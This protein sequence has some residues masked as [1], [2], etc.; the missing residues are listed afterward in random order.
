[1]PSITVEG[2]NDDIL[3]FT[4]LDGHCIP[5]MPMALWSMIKDAPGVYRFHFVGNLAI[6]RANQ[7]ISRPPVHTVRLFVTRIYRWRIKLSTDK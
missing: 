6:A 1:M 3:R 2:R 4:D 5:I 7:L